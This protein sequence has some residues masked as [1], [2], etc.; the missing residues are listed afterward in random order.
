MIICPNPSAPDPAGAVNAPLLEQAAV[1]LGVKAS[2]YSGI[3]GLVFTISL[4]VA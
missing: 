1:D 3:E 4:P 2:Q